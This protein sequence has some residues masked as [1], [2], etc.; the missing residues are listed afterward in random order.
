MVM[1]ESMIILGLVVSLLACSLIFAGMFFAVRFIFPRLK[2]NSKIKSSKFLKIEE[3]LP[4]EEAQTIKQVYY[5]IM[6]IIF[7][8]IMLYSIFRWQ[9]GR[10]I[11]IAI[12]VVFSVYLA[13]EMNKKSV[14]RKFL[15]F[16]LIPFD[17]IFTL[18]GGDSFGS[19]IFYVLNMLHCLSYVYMIKVYYQKF[20][21]YTQTNGLGITI[22]LLYL[23]VLFSFLFT[24]VVEDVSPLDS[25]VMVSNAFTSNGYA[26]LGSSGIGKINAILLVWA[27]FILSG[28]GSATLAV[29]IVRRSLF[30]RFDH[31]EDLIKKNKKN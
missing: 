15:F 9:S 25:I 17:S 1:S 27:G 30:K 21:D 12:D 5:L 10:H 31:I 6:I 2:N 24:I 22:M 11:I 28:V 4:M 13:Y 18:I 26:V 19:M 3:Y 29:A 7:V 8:F 14:Q 16:F 23:I 20:R